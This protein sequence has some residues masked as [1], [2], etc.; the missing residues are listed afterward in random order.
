VLSSQFK[1]DPLF[2]P[3]PQR[4]VPLPV[5][6]FL[7]TAQWHATKNGAGWA[8]EVR[9]ADVPVHS[10]TLAAASERGGNRFYPVRPTNVDPELYTDAEANQA[11]Y[12]YE[13]QRGGRASDSIA[14]SVEA[15]YFDRRSG[16]ML[17]GTEESANYNLDRG[18]TLRYENESEDRGSFS[19]LSPPDS[20]ETL[21]DADTGLDPNYQPREYFTSSEMQSQ[22]LTKARSP[23]V[24]RIGSDPRLFEEVYSG[25]DT[26][27]PHSARA[28]EWGATGLARGGGYAYIDGAHAAENY[29]DVPRHKGPI[30]AEQFDGFAGRTGSGEPLRRL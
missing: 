24:N 13:W 9:E 29:P 18:K 7:E 17:T 28:A 14:D 19:Y 3:G 10:G 2:D 5:R 16:D 11:H 4:E 6:S 1:Q 12:E 15:D 27:R 22:G 8:D 21:R 23:M 30:Q 26:S 25:F 20:F